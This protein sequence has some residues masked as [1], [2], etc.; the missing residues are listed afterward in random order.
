M[1]NWRIANKTKKGPL[2]SEDII[3]KPQG[4]SIIPA[5]FLPTLGNSQETI[6]LLN[7]SE[8]IVDQISYDTAPEFQSYSLLNNDWQWTKLTT[9]G[10]ANI[11]GLNQ[12]TKNS[13]SIMVNPSDPSQVIITGIVVTLPAMFSTQYFLVKTS[14]S[15]NL[16]QIYSSKKLFPK[17]TI[18]QQITASGEI[19]DIETGQ[20]LKI[21][22]AEDIRIIGESVLTEPIISNTQEVIQPPHPRL[23]RVEGEITSKKSPRLTLTDAKGD[24]E[25][26]LAKGTGLSISSYAIGDKLMI[27]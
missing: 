11:A 16:F 21:N 2:I 15:E 7:Q 17:L 23:V 26:N 13:G 25:I 9:P 27:T 20:R 3:L 10:K 8:K 12:E 14:D 18:G 1:K 24:I 4:F 19:S 5:K 6:K 22:A